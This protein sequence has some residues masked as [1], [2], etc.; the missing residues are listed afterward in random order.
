MTNRILSITNILIII[1]II[2]FIIQNNI[3]N[4]TL[5]FGLNPYFFE[6]KLYH[7][8]LSTI[9]VHGGI[10]HIAMNMFVLFQFG[11][12]IEEHI[13]IFKYLL[14]YLIGGLLTSIGSLGYM[15]ITTDWANLVGAS[16]AISVL[17]GYFALK[18]RYR[19]NGIII[20]ILFI[21]FAPLLLNMPI[22]WY[23][24]LIGFALGWIMG[25]LL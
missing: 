14:L 24:H 22:A 25:Y 18:D 9:F 8:L 3:P 15:Y 10:A 7:Q 6:Y 11:N 12:I 21:S 19:R 2:M 5:Y 1:N 13:G 4:G 17:L 16:G 23:S 20:W